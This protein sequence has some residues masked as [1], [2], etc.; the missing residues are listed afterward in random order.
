MS[1]TKILSR[2]NVVCAI[3]YDGPVALV[4]KTARAIYGNF[5]TAELIKLGQYRAA[6]ASAVHSGNPEELTLVASSTNDEAE[7]NIWE[8]GAYSIITK[9]F[10]APYAATAGLYYVALLHNENDAGGETVPAIAAN[11]SPVSAMLGSLGATDSK[12]A[13]CMTLAG[14]TALPTPTVLTSKLTGAASIPLVFLY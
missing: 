13:F 10:S 5:P 11:S 14:Q 7:A 12:T 4:D 6:A 9:A 8:A 2:D 3:G 1:K